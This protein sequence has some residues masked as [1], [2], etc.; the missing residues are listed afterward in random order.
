[1]DTTVTFDQFRE[2]W[3]AEIIEG[4]PNTIEKGNRFSRKILTHWLDIDESTDEIFYCDG[5]GDGGIDIAYLDEGNGEDDTEIEGH[6]W[7]LVQSKYGKAFQGDTTL[8]KEGQKLIGTLDN[9][10]R[11]LSSLT[12]DVIERLNSF[13]CRASERDRIILVFAT[14]NPLSKNERN[15]L[16]DVRIMGQGLLGPLFDVEAVSVDNI[17]QRTLESANSTRP[18]N[19]RLE[20][21]NLPPFLPE[22][23]LL[24][25]SVSLINLYTFLE[26]FKEKTG[27]IDQLYE[28]NLRRFLGSR[29][30][31]N[32]GIQTTLKKEPE[33]FGLYNNGITIVVKDFL[34]KEN[35]ILRL[36]DPFI[37]NG[38]QTTRTI[39][40]V[41]SQKMRAGGT[42]VSPTIDDWE[43]KAKQGIVVT[44]IV[45]IGHNDLEMQNITTFTNSQNAVK[46][47]DFNALNNYFKK[48]K[49]DME[50]KY[51]IFVEI[52]RGAWETQCAL[53]DQHKEVKKFDRHA[54]AFDL[55]KVYG[56]GWL[57]ESGNA[58][59]RNAAFLPNGNVF[60][61]IVYDKN[62]S[63][64]LNADDLFAAYQLQQAADGYK[65]GRTAQKDT[66]RQSR[67]LFY[68]LVIELLKNIQIHSWAD[69]Q[70]TNKDV[71]QALNKLFAANKQADLLDWAIMAL[72]E[73]MMPR[74]DNSILNEPIL[75]NLNNNLNSFLKSEYLGKFD[76]CPVFK[77]LITEYGR[78]IGRGSPGQKSPREEI[79]DVIKK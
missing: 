56:A 43:S 34:L 8:L 54:N 22:N 7:Y 10:T 6:R 58:F 77:R 73:Y 52:Q 67:Y 29:G 71:T 47:T 61:Q 53:Q 5:T 1:M 18:I 46:A 59:G 69:Y 36:E 62:E 78:Q 76:K 60:K 57:G 21:N 74:V 49:T 4:N 66:R 55:I 33:K 37:V 40:E 9:P 72:D 70:P 30:K 48:W 45:R 15:T 35:N 65:F 63:E 26:S 79:L 24:V 44:K 19:I 28:K 13:K 20:V 16:R 2:K 32:R 31:V 75:E 39:W 17:Y 25:C 51:N 14:V 12:Q 41:C 3:L 38:C 27:D 50:N 23:N 68:Q 42:G 64:V 11:H